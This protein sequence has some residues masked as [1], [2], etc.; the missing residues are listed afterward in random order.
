MYLF[1]I[2]Y[3]RDCDLYMNIENLSVNK[4]LLYLLTSSL[5]SI[6]ALVETLLLFNY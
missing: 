3:I 1:L 6:T 4:T 5:Y 2:K